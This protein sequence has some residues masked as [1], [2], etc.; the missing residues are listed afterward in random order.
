MSALKRLDF[1]PVNWKLGVGGLCIPVSE[2]GELVF[3]WFVGFFWLLKKVADSMARSMCA[4]F[5]VW[6]TG[7]AWCSSAAPCPFL[8]DPPQQRLGARLLCA[9]S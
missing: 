5:P 6:V 4:S 2:F 3:C 9:F 1:I 7:G 8:Q